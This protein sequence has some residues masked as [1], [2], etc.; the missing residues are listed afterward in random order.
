MES[1]FLEKLIIG[2]T[3]LGLSIGTVNKGVLAQ[4]SQE[5]ESFKSRKTEVAQDSL[6][7]NFEKVR[8]QF[9]LKYQ[10]KDYDRD[11]VKQEALKL[12]YAFLNFPSVQG[13]EWLDSFKKDF[14]GIPR[15]GIDILGA[16][17]DMDL[18][19]RFP[20]AKEILRGKNFR[21]MRLDVWKNHISY[22]NYS[23]PQIIIPESYL[24]GIAFE[25]QGREFVWFQWHHI[26][27]KYFDLFPPNEKPY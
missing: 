26:P 10:H 25:I 15:E 20:N 4:K 21:V 14:K 13:K 23:R 7:V 17:S 8:D 2:A 5:E 6:V 3:S 9:L 24:Y 12:Y 22:G 19:D 18:L 27:K 16:I 1:K 11:L